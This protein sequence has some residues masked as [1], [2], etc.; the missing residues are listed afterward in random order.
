MPLLSSDLSFPDPA[1]A[2][3]EGVVAIGGDLSI[4]RLLLAYKS[5]IF[6]WY[7]EEEPL[8]WWSPDPRFILELDEF[9]LRKS[10]RKKLSSFE[11]KYNTAFEDVIEECSKIDR[12]G[13]KGKWLHEEMVKAYKELHTLGYAVSV[14]S[15]QN[16][17]LVGGLYGIIIGR[18]FCGESMFSKVSDASKVAFN[19]LV[20]K[21]KKENFDFIDAQ[22]YTDHL[23]SLGAKEISRDEFLK[24]IKG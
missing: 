10:L 3:K 1:K 16:K 12:P 2:I 14:E 23:N 13:Q 19:F 11:V 15:Y 8:I 21:L 9:K 17:E 24:R 22:V 6:P 5:G 20:E 18:V 7:S 4:E